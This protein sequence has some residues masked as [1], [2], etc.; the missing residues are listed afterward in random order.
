VKTTVLS[1][2]VGAVLLAAIEGAA[3]RNKVSKCQE[4]ANALASV[5]MLGVVP[6]EEVKPV[7]ERKPVEQPKINKVEMPSQRPELTARTIYEPPAHATGCRCGICAM[8]R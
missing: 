1:V 6:G 8:K 4:A 5:Y 7:R 2:R 3:E